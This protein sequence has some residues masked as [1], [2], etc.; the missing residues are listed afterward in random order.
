MKILVTGGAGFIGSHT[1]DRLLELG[2]D[3]VVLDALTQPVHRNGRPAY[4]SPGVDFYQGDIRNRDLLTNLLRRVDAV[5]HFAA[6]QDYLPDFSRF[7]DVNVVSTALL[8]EIIV[9]ERLDI[10]RVVVASSQSAMGEGLYRCPADGEQVP[11]MRPEKALAAGQWDIP[12]PQCGG[13]L[14]MQATPERI[15]NPQN[16]YGM[17]KL[18]EEMV[19]IN[20]GR[21]YDIPTVALRYSIVQGPRQ[22][23]YNA[24]SGA[25]R[26]FC[27][28]YLQGM[29][30]TLYEDGGAIRDYV[31]IDDVVDANV[32]VLEDD[33]AAGRVFNVGGGKAVTTREFADIVMR[34]Y[35]SERAGG[36][37]RRVPLRRHAAHPL[38]HQR[39]AGAGLGAEAH[40]GRLGRR[41]RR[42][43]RRHGRTRRG[44]GRGQRAD[45]RPRRRP[46]GGGV[47]AFLLAAG[48]GSRLRPITDTIPK[49]MLAIDD[50]PLLDI[51]LDAFD[52]A[53][54]DEVLVNLHHLPDVV[55]RHLAARDGP[56]AVRTVFEPELLGSAGTLL[57][58]R[59]W[60]DG[61]E[62]FLACNADNLTDF[63]LRS[64]IDAHRRARRD[65]HPDGVPLA[66]PVGRRRRGARRDRPGHRIRGEA[67]PAGLRPGECRDV[68]LPSE[69]ARRDRASAAEGH[70]L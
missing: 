12:C 20:L 32:L 65:R 5:Y 34:Q 18:G 53:G 63:D 51:W 16:A 49:C 13:P 69:R 64:L 43:A 23:V 22:S 19:A 17:S 35:G 28:S 40:A 47:K 45:A 39:A 46:Q 59:Q 48:I 41:V 24:Y 8:Y 62:F 36:G 7:T 60:V 38:G 26:I 15:S 52:R 61:E 21:R 66:E 50:R 1:C 58:N 68:R 29:P 33:R 14:E 54:V 37:D 11:G 70:R 10:A 3:V 27:L 6:Y 4:L 55:R 67:E 44:A 56:P 30:P 25:C 31:N 2:H 42:V 9:A 57:A